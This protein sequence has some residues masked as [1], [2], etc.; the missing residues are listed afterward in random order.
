[1]GLGCLAKRH[2][3]LLNFSTAPYAGRQSAI[4]LTFKVSLLH[5]KYDGRYPWRAQN[6]AAGV[7]PWPWVE[8]CEALLPKGPGQGVL[9]RATRSCTPDCGSPP[10]KFQGPLRSTVHDERGS[11]YGRQV[12]SNGWLCERATLSETAGQGF[13]GKEDASVIPSVSVTFAMSVG[14]GSGGP[15]TSQAHTSQENVAPRIPVVAD[16]A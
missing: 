3:L 6:P 16:M 4:K 7:T 11:K 9:S 14:R 5:P 8:P 2:Q 1:M 10:S 15:T 12:L 13:Y